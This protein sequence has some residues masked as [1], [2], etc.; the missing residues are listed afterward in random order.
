MVLLASSLA[1][2]IP[3]TLTLQGKL[4]NQAGASQSGTYNFAFKIYDNYSADVSAAVYSKNLSLTTDAN[5]VYDV[6]LNN[7]TLPFDK[8]YYLGIT[9]GADDES[10]P[11][12]NLTSS[13]YTFRA[14]VS[15]N[16]NPNQSYSVSSINVSGNLTIGLSSAPA[17]YVDSTSNLI[18]IGINNPAYLLQ[19]GNVDRAVNISNVLFVNGSSGN[20][21]I[22][23]SNPIYKFQIQGNSS[24]DLMAEMMNLN[25]TARTSFYVENSGAKNIA[26]HAYGADS[27][28]TV[29]GNAAANAVA[30]TAGGGP[31][32]IFIGDT[33]GARDIIFG[34]G[35]N[36]FVRFA[37]SGKVGINTTAPAQT[38]TVQGT[39]NVTPPGASNTS[40]FVTSAGFVGIGT[41]NPAR[42]LTVNG[43]TLPAR[44]LLQ[45]NNTGSTIGDGLDVVEYISGNAAIWNYEAGNLTFAT[46][47]TERMIIDSFGN[48]GIG[49]TAPSEKLHIYRNDAVA[50]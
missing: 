12:I 39:L 44:I 8:E 11:R 17:L 47:N 30:I 49:T 36:E 1:F 5:G 46:S 33:S 45:N 29:F 21:G 16:L 25:S 6:M 28:A 23:T 35:S 41:A 37:S 42:V 14:N 10:T 24:S 31:S 15:E 27:V 13:P 43:N 3:Q 22:G 26:L 32:K 20:V 7:I 2:A 4:T 34:G 48:V 40:F 38:L 9:V 18:G 50:D 19:I